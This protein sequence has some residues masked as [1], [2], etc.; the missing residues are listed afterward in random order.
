MNISNRELA[1]RLK[2][3]PT[4]VSRIRSG[5]RTPSIETIWRMHRV[6]GLDIY[7][8]VQAA[9]LGRAAFSKYFQLK[10]CDLSEERIEGIRRNPR[11]Q[12]PLVDQNTIL[13]TP[14]EWLEVVRLA[15][16]EPTEGEEGENGDSELTAEALAASIRGYPLAS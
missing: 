9:A 11:A 10:T 14:E 3:D 5:Q 2:L 12:R 16:A 8:L 15:R 7:Q 13:A 1:K 6:L 4:Y